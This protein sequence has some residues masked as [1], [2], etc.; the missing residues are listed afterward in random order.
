MPCTLSTQKR[1][2][3]AH[4]DPTMP[5]WSSLPPELI[6]HIGD[7]FLAA[8]DLDYYMNFRAVCLSWCLATADPCEDA[9]NPRFMP[10]NWVLL[11]RNDD[12]CIVTLMNINTGRLLSKNVPLLAMYH[13]V[14]VTSGGLFLL[15]EAESPYQAFMFNPFT[16][17]AVVRFKVKI[18]WGGV[19]M[20]VMTTSPEMIFITGQVEGNIMWADQSCEQFH[21]S[22]VPYRHKPTCL[23]SF[24]GNVYLIHREGAILS[25][26]PYD[27]TKAF[28]A[29]NIALATTIPSLSQGLPSYYL[30]ESEGE[31]LRVTRTCYS[32]PGEQLVHRVDTV[33]KVLEPVSSIG[34]RALFVSHVRCLSLDASKFPTVES[35][36]IYFV[37]TIPRLRA[38]PSNLEPSFMTIHRLNDGSEERIMLDSDTIE[39]CFH[40]FTLAHVLANFCKSLYYADRETEF[41]FTHESES[42]DESSES[43]LRII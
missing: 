6:C 25:I 9:K 23:T 26:V 17:S 30:V 8:N 31:L 33:K 34:N 40:P 42:D 4:L 19:R 28:S 10:N 27:A 22:W 15:G 36:C 5:D 16:E 35:G 21:K 13:F 41:F 37:D 12:N 38:E 32:L 24:A 39:G 1:P 3:P 7:C 11:E 14:G 18:Q 20:V 43:D 29:H 2:R